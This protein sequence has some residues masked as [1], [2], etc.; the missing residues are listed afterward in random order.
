MINN[1]E[2]DKNVPRSINI[3][4][5]I[6]KEKK[7]GKDSWKFLLSLYIK[8]NFAMIYIMAKG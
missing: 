3:L 1:M 6:V 5:N 8:E 4:G 7:K 2:K